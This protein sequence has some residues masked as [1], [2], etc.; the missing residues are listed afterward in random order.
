MGQPLIAIIGGIDKT[1]DQAAARQAAEELGTELAKRGCRILVYGNEPNFFETYVVKGY[2]ESGAEIADGAIEVRYPEDITGLF[3]GEKAGD[4]RFI[5]IPLG[6][7]WETTFYPSLGAADGMLLLGGG[8]TTKVSGLIGAGFRMP[9]VALAVFGGCAGNV[10]DHLLQERQHPAAQD[11]LNLMGRPWNSESATNCVQS[12]LNQ[13]KRRELEAQAKQAQASEVERKRKL[14]MLAIVGSLAFLA[15]LICLAS[16]WPDDKVSRTFLWMLF[17]IPAI[18]GLSGAVIRVV[19][20]SS[21]RNEAPVEMLPATSTI[22]LGFWAGGVAGALF[23]VAQIVALNALDKGQA[24]R[25]FPFAVLIGLL[26]G[27]TLDKVFPRLIKVE[28][29]LQTNILEQEQKQK[30]STGKTA[31]GKTA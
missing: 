30:P 29:P 17:G 28:V 11:D 19:Y 15:V 2:L 25:L 1:R 3:E 18:A 5:R 7:Q 24:T 10:R 16:A 26:T 8:Y 23:V 20:D 22:A 31:R 12:L 4:Q 9:I 6:S 27:L 14:A 13:K 21:K